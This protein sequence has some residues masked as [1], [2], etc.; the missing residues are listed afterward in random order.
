[1]VAP[2]LMPAWRKA[3]AA[4]G[5][6]DLLEVALIGAAFSLYFAVRSAV[7][8]RPETAYANALDIIGLQQS[9][10]VFWEDDVNSWTAGRLFWAQAANA[11]YF[12]LL[13][14]LL[15][16]FG[17]WVYYFRRGKYTFI[18]DTLLASGAMGLVVFWLYPVAPPRELPA[19]ASEFDPD[20]P[21]YVFGFVDTVKVH[22]R[23]AHDSQ[24]TGLWVNPYAAMPCL[25]VG[26]NLIM[27]IGMV[28]V[29]WRERWM[30]L[31]VPIAVFLP[32]SQSLAVVATANHY[33]LDI[34]AGVLVSLGGFPVALAMRRW[35]YPALGRASALL[36]ARRAAQEGPGPPWT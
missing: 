16:V 19:L 29:V 1:M 36:R 4:L 6:R 8:G 17:L 20:A 9:L 31:A 10:G 3:S 22:M 21:G 13:F 32:I 34:P 25:H 28:M 15:I 7:V 23:Y 27:G 12:W 33:L 2:G 5:W 26:W 11:V 24:S 35:A 18:R 14:P 30:W